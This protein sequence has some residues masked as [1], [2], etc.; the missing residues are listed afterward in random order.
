[1]VA[2]PIDF[3]HAVHAEMYARFFACIML[4]LSG[5]L[6]QAET[7][8]AALL[9]RAE[10]LRD[11]R[12]RVNAC[13]L[14]GTVAR[15][16]GDGIAARASTDRGQELS[17]TDPRLLWTRIRLEYETGSPLAVDSLVKTLLEVV[18]LVVTGP[19]LAQAS[20]ALM[21]ASMPDA[22]LAAGI[23]DT[24]GSTAETVLPFPT[25]TDLVRVY[26]PRQPGARRTHS[27][28]PK[29]ASAV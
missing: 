29:P 13:W 22:V 25:A 14:A 26:Q 27:R 6:G 4:W 8:A 11:R 7:Y 3:E 24:A 19:D 10:H 23:T 9:A 21:L 16:R 20:T 5:E 12:W 2:R 17:P 15:D 18:P 28:G 1:M